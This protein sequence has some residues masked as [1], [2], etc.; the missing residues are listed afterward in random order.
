MPTT[1]TECVD[2]LHEAADRL[3]ESPSKADYE[4]L[5]LTPASATV[6]R[7]MGGWNEAKR[8]A[9]LSTAA[10]TG[11]RTEEQPDDV[12]IPDDE[13]WAD[14]SVDRRWHY[15]NSEWNTERDYQRKQRLRKWVYERPVAVPTALSPTRA[16][17]TSTTARTPRRRQPSVR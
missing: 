10:S 4:S 16:V 15:R 14:L 8:R 1:V 12:T 17:S 13:T 6:V 3:G 11:S 2:A 5:G 7:T 9:G